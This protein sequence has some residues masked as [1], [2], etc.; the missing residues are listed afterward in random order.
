MALLAYGLYLSL[1]VYKE[2][3]FLQKLNRIDWLFIS[4]TVLYSVVVIRGI[5]IA[6]LRDGKP[7]TW[8]WAFTWPND[9]LLAV[10]LFEAIFLRRSAL[11]MGWGLIAKV[12]G[13]FGIAVLLTS[14]GSFSLWLAAYGYVPWPQNAFGW[15]I[16]YIASAAYVL[17]PAYQLEASRVARARLEEHIEDRQAA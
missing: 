1:K 5:L 16:W 17:A 4:G 13:T 9:L 6:L 11:N 2:F 8:N 12:W 10:L 14:F 3:G 7:V 15:Y